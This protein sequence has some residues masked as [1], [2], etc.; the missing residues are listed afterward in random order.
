MLI[1]AERAFDHVDDA[2][3]TIP[4][5]VADAL[6]AA[7]CDP[8]PDVVTRAELVVA[9]HVGDLDARSPEVMALWV[10]LERIAGRDLGQHLLERLRVLSS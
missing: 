6:L 4:P 8:S 10:M 3:A 9:L 2:L 7:W 5:T 1:A